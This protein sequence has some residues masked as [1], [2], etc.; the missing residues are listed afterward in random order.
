MVIVQRTATGGRAA[1]SVAPP[2]G[3]MRDGDHR[4]RRK[5]ESNSRRCDCRQ[6]SD[7]QDVLMQRGWPHYL[8]STRRLRSRPPP[9]PTA[10]GSRP[11]SGSGRRPVVAR[12]GAARLSCG[13]SQQPG[14]H[15]S[16]GWCGGRGDPGGVSTSARKVPRPTGGHDAVLTPAPSRARRTRCRRGGQSST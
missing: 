1:F 14:G 7:R 11:D 4:V 2:Q 8:E 15:D 5:G 16:A 6:A 13:S 12:A 3:S 10:A 9:R